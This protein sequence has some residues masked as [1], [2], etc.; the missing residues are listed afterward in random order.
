MTC[1]DI[2]QQSQKKET[3]Q[4]SFRG[5][6][7]QWSTCIIPFENHKPQDSCAYYTLDFLISSDLTIKL[8]NSL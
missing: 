7:A 5:I 2:E 3:I 4:S 1:N 8:F 6:L